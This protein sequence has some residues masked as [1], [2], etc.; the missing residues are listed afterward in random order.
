MSADARIL[1]ACLGRFGVE[2]SA[3]EANAVAGYA[4]RE[5]ML[6]VLADREVSARFDA[7]HGRPPMDDD[8]DELLD[9]Y[10]ALEARHTLG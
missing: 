6:M 9:I 2:I 10:F 8:V 7:A 3:D 5:A 1:R 4:P